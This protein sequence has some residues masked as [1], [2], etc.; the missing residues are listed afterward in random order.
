MNQCEKVLINNLKN[1]IDQLI[2]HKRNGEKEITHLE[3]SISELQL[4][5]TN[6][7]QQHKKE[8]SKRYLNMK[9]KKLDDNII[10][11]LRFQDQKH[12]L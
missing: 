12:M 8:V 4:N 7:H 3:Q 9:R 6:T 11:V 10:F 5:L 2:E 1:D